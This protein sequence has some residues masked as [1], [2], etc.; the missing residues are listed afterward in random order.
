MGKKC[1]ATRFSRS[2]NSCTRAIKFLQ[3]SE[4]EKNDRG[5]DM[6]VRNKKK[7]SEKETIKLQALKI[8]EQVRDGANKTN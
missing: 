4:E 6:K 3:V 8:A 5:G 1:E 7:L 2:I